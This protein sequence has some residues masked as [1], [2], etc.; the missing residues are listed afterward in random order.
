[1]VSAEGIVTSQVWRLPGW[2]R[3]QQKL[4]RIT[5]NWEKASSVTLLP[6]NKYRWLNIAIYH[7]E[8]VNSCSALRYRGAGTQ[9]VLT[10]L[11][12]SKWIPIS[13]GSCGIYTSGLLT[14][15]AQ[16]QPGSLSSD[17]PHYAWCLPVPCCHKP[18]INSHAFKEMKPYRNVPS[19]TNYTVLMPPINAAGNNA[20]FQMLNGLFFCPCKL[21]CHR[22][23]NKATVLPRSC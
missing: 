10:H 21:I 18:L 1:M 5:V 20:V 13:Q 11:P 9:L 22:T 14:F 16:V 3:C 4:L 23:L 7:L 2:I 19:V 12:Q 6:R 17:C 8:E 15:K